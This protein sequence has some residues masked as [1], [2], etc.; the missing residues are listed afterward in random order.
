MLNSEQQLRSIAITKVAEAFLRH[1]IG[2]KVLNL[3]ANVP[4]D[5]LLQDIWL[6]VQTQKIYL[7]EGAR[8][9]NVKLEGELIIQ[10][11][12]YHH[13]RKHGLLSVYESLLLSHKAE[14]ALRVEIYKDLARM[15]RPAPK[16]VIMGWSDMLDL[17]PSWSEKMIRTYNNHR[18]TKDFPIISAAH[19][20]AF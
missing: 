18:K 7:R 4:V 15:S 9:L 1:R 3:T 10:P 5:S 19:E 14:A 12:Y 13:S 6:I 11:T 2:E 16:S 8:D 17:D 20:F